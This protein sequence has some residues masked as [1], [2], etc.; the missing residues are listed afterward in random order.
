[1]FLGIEAVT[2]EL[3]QARPTIKAVCVVSGDVN[4]KASAPWRKRGSETYGLEQA[5]ELLGGV[6]IV[7]PGRIGVEVPE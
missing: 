4:V 7:E 3:L 5:A 6:A 1:M 2:R